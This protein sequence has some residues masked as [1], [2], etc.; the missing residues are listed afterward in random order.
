MKIIA[1]QQTPYTA[2]F[3]K[4]FI[5]PLLFGS[6]LIIQCLLGHL[7]HQFREKSRWNRLGV[8]FSQLKE[9]M[10]SKMP[11]GFYR[12]YG[13]LRSS[14]FYPFKNEHFLCLALKPPDCQVFLAFALFLRHVFLPLLSAVIASSP[15][16]HLLL[17]HVWAG[18]HVTKY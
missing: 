5:I 6:L 9:Y 2:M 3:L 12:E 8:P 16:I 4:Q 10:Q 18:N 11:P 14:I 1:A 7:L 15:A 17:E 13:S